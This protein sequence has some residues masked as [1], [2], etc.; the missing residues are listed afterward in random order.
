MIAPGVS[1][2]N[3]PCARKI[4][5]NAVHRLE[6]RV[7]ERDRTARTTPAKVKTRAD[8]YNNP[9]FYRQLGKDSQRLM[10]S[11]L[12]VFGAVGHVVESTGWNYWAVRVANPLSPLSWLV[13]SS[14]S[15]KANRYPGNGKSRCRARQGRQ[16]AF[17]SNDTIT[18]TGECGRRSYLASANWRTAAWS[19]PS[20]PP[21]NFELVSSL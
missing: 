2:Y 13:V 7:L 20:G 12:E 14:S 16:R 11:A 21:V 5:P 8:V 18:L 4:L 10:T 6:V 9:D 19:G 3:A 1:P 17:N 15:R